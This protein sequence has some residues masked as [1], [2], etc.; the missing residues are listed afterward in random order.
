LIKIIAIVD[1]DVGMGGGGNQ[2]LNAVLQMK[3]LSRGRFNFEIVTTKKNNISYFKS[4]DITGIYFNVTILDRFLAKLSRLDFMQSLHARNKVV[5]SLEK[6]LIKQGCD[7]VYFPTPSDL[8]ADLKTLN[9]INTLWD[10]CHRETPEFPE[11]RDFNTF[12]N[13]EA[14]YRNKFAPALVT[15]TDSVKLADMAARLYGVD[16]QRF[17]AMPFTPATFVSDDNKI[18]ISTFFEQ[19]ELKKGYFFY[20]AQFWSH[21]NHIRI[22]QALKILR[23]KYSW[24]PIVVFSGKDYGN[25]MHI[26]KFISSNQMESQVKILGFVPSEFMRALYENA[27]ALVMPTYFG[28]TNIPP[29]EAWALGVPLIYSKHLH[30]QARSAALLVDPDCADDLAKSMLQAVKEGVRNQLLRAGQERLLEIEHERNA[31]EAELC[32]IIERFAVRRE[33]WE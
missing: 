11:V 14:S 15:L 22:L 2:A 8:S 26:R 13:R 12:S 17:I 30:E 31:A 33:C 27:T 24:S 21:K 25:L 19:Y 6:I 23:D 9:Y 7:L 1:N 20:P 5:G 4:Y 32:L 29:L 28:P 3:R 18:D 10:L 16:R